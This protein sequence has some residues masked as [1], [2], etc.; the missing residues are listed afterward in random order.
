MKLNQDLI[1]ELLL[2]VEENGIGKS[3]KRGI[4]IY[5]YTQDEIYYHFKK[6]VEAGYINGEIKELQSNALDY[7]DLS[8]KGHQYLEHI[9][10]KYIWEEVKRKLELDGLKTGAFEIIK[11][12]ADNLIRKKLN[13]K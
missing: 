1:R 4:E 5:G 9:R 2:Y 8:W 12:I 10:D 7:W 3:P 11:E 6:L 13:I